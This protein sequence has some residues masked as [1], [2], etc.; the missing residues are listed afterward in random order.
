MQQPK[1]AMDSTSIYSKRMLSN[2]DM[3]DRTSG[4]TK[5]MFTKKYLQDASDLNKYSMKLKAM[6][7]NKK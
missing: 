4:K 1:N 3:A 7:K 5:E 2:M 6:K